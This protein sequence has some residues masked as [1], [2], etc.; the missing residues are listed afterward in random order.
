VD[1]GLEAEDVMTSDGVLG[2]IKVVDLSEQVPG[3]YATRM[4]A[5]LGADVIKVARSCSPRKTAA[6]GT[7]RST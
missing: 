2:G 1:D 7:C 3:P 5:G 6:S 4:L